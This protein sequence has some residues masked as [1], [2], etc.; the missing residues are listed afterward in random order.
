MAQNSGEGMFQMHPCPN[1]L[2][3]PHFLSRVMGCLDPWDSR[4][5]SGDHL[6][7]GWGTR[8][9]KNGQ[10]VRRSDQADKFLFF[11]HRLYTHRSK[12]GDGG[13]LLRLW[14]IHLFPGTGY[15]LGKQFSRKIRTEWVIRHLST[16]FI[17]ICSLLTSGSMSICT[18]LG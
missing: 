12:K 16:R 11:P 6:R 10:Q 17:A 13:G 3:S 15:W 8:N 4:T 5:G 2:Q 1:T 18:Q 7:R 9:S 14:A